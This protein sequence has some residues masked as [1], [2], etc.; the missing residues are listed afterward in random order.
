LKSGNNIVEIVD[1]TLSNV[2]GKRIFDRLDFDLSAGQA[3]V[4]VGP[5]GSGKTSLIELII[6]KRTPESGAVMV[7]GRKMEAG[8]ERLLKRTRNRIGGVGGIFQPISYQTVRENLVY[9]LIL[10]GINASNRKAR[11]SNVLSQLN[12]LSKKDEKAGNLSQGEKVLLMLGRAVVADQPL[13][14]IDEPLAGLDVETSSLVSAFL[15]RLAVA[16]HSLIILTS[17]QAGLGIPDVSRY[18]IENGRLR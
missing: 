5:T 16:G 1:V 17:S 7:F 8:N 4:I 15:K 3:A 6:G 14:L 13:L 18:H 12:L 2:A 11:V 10:R 9:P